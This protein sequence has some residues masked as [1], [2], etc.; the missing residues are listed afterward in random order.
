MTTVTTTA[1]RR[2]F[3][4]L[5]AIGALALA[6][7]LTLAVLVGLV[8]TRPSGDPAYVPAARDAAGTAVTAFLSVSAD[9]VDAD[10]DRVLSLS[11]GRFRREYAAE[12]AQLRTAMVQNKVHSTATVLGIGLTQAGPTTA[13]AL[14]A[15]DAS[16]RNTRTP[17]PNVSHYR[18]RL[19]LVRSHDRWLVSTLTLE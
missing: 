19:S 1:H 17:K 11:T 2:P 18:I 12:K 6:L 4:W 10:M 5:V 14:V 16:V 3:G 15:A 7:L 8:V 9:S 13:S